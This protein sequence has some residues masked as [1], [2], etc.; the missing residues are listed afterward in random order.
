MRA[1]LFLQKHPDQMLLWQIRAATALILNDTDAGYEAGQKLLAA[2][3]ADSNDPNLQQLISK[4]NLKG[5]LDKQKIEKQ[6]ETEEKQAVF[7]QLLLGKWNVWDWDLPDVSFWGMHKWVYKGY[8]IAER[9]GTEIT[10]KLYNNGG[11]APNGNSGIAYRGIIEGF[12]IKDI[13]WS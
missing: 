4:L 7:D 6:R 12:D 10:F 8:M 13:K 11:L 5:W 2:G 3:A 9:N 1:A